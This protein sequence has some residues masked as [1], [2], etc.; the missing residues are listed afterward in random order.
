MKILAVLTLFLTSLSTLACPD[1]TAEA[2]RRD[3]QLQRELAAQYASSADFV[4]IANVVQA[5]REHWEAELNIVEQFKGLPLSVQSVKFED[6]LA[7][8]GGCS[9]SFWFQKSDVAAGYKYIIYVMDGKIL[10]AGIID[11]SNGIISLSEE[12]RIIKRSVP[13]YPIKTPQQ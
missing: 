4:Y 3:R 9:A 5:D 10:R 6:G 11:N 12:I 7:E 8:V 13:K 1:A 2:H